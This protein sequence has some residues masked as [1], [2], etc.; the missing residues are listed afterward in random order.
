[1]KITIVS[2]TTGNVYVQ[3]PHM[4]DLPYLISC[5][6]YTDGSRAEEIAETLLALGYA[7]MEWFTL[8]LE[9]K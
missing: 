5:I 7:D 8:E 1:M 2:K 3:Y 4:E 9:K 6:A